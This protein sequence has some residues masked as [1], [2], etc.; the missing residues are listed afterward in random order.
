ME[1]TNSSKL[2][3]QRGKYELEMRKQIVKKH[4]YDLPADIGLNIIKILNIF[5]AHTNIS[6]K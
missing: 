6:N 2:N 1:M 3:L 4:F 5:I